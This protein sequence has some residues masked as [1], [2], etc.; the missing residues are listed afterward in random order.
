MKWNCVTT[1][2]NHPPP[3]KE[4]KNKI[5]WEK[6]GFFPKGNAQVYFINETGYKRLWV[7]LF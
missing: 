7:Q 1:A 6:L 3:K 5:I 2:Q 4:T